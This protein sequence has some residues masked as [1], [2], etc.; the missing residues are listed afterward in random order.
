MEF[1]PDYHEYPDF[2]PA[3]L[4]LSHFTIQW[5]WAEHNFNVLL[6]ALSG[7]FFTGAQYTA[8]LGNQS[9]ADLM[10]A[11][12]RRKEKDPEILSLIEFCV[13]A[14]GRIKDNRNSLLHAHSVTVGEEGDGKPRWI[15]ASN[16][17]RSL[18]VY[19]LADEDDIIENLEAACQLGMLLP[20]IT[21]WYIGRVP[22]KKRRPSLGI[23]PLPN[24]L[25][26]TPIAP[27][28]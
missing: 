18:H 26:P 3:M 11:T 13:K 28:E 9:R 25:K 5:N 4:A 1:F 16:N 10:L 27:Q 21:T 23:F 6:W 20:Q 8:G 24:V 17:P 2:Q 7:D 15:R 19:C 14:F 22:K 12:A